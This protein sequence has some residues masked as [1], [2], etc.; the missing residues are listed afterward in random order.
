MSKM[1]E[2]GRSSTGFEEGEVAAISYFGFLGVLF[3]II[4]KKSDFVRFHALQST[5][6][7]S[8]LLVFW[9]CVKWIVSLQFM[10]WAPGMAAL[11]FAL[12]MMYHAYHGEEYKFPVIGKMAFN[13]IFDT[14]PEPEDLLAPSQNEPRD[15]GGAEGGG[16]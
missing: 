7:F 14:E 8:T 4:E 2:D 16:V 1:A 5:L 3:L 15:P 13:A 6:G 11:A 10:W 12:F 9:L